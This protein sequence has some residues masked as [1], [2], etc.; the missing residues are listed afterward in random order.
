M[1]EGFRATLDFSTTAC[2]DNQGNTYSRVVTQATTGTQEGTAIYWC[3]SIGTPSGT[4]TVT[5]TPGGSGGFYAVCR[6]VEASYSGTA[7]VD[8]WTSANGSGTAVSSGAMSTTANADSLLAAVM[9]TVNDEASITVE[10]LSPAWVEEFEELTLTNFQPGEGDT[11]IVTS[12]GAYT[13]NWTM[14]TSRDWAA[15]IAA[16]KDGGGLSPTPPF[17]TMLSAKF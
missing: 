10:S 16:F 15:C 12:T 1:V 17:R 14:A 13:A 4:F 2:A 11:R 7:E 9:V 6:A 5:V 8:V 3:P